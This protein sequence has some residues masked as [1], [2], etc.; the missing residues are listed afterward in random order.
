[1]TLAAHAQQVNVERGRGPAPA[2]LGQH[3][4]VGLGRRVQ[5]VTELTV[6]GGP[7]V[8]HWRR[9]GHV[10]E[11]RLAGLL[12]VALVVVMGDESFVTPVD[13]N[14]R[15]VDIAAA[16]TDPLEE[17][18]SRAA[19]GQHDVRRS[20]GV[21]RVPDRFHQPVPGGGDQCCSVGVRFDLRRHR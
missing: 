13:V 6:A 2:G 9:D 18:D 4:G 11:Q 19:A 3:L 17:A 8:D 10:V 12:F 16:L 7:P 1:M 5:R 20:S 15:P 21:D 14:L